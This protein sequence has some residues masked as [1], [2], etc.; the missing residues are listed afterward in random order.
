[1]SAAYPKGPLNMEKVLDKI[2]EKQAAFARIFG[3]STYNVQ[4]CTD[5]QR[6]TWRSHGKREIHMPFHRLQGA[7]AEAESLLVT[8]LFDRRA[9]RWERHHVWVVEGQLRRGESNILQR[10]DFY[11]E[12]ASWQILY[13]EGYNL[14]NDLIRYYLLNAEE[15]SVMSRRGRWYDIRHSG[16][17]PA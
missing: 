13:G 10:R 5:P 14:K 15:M 17:E 8:A 11:I 16:G 1:M 3:E 12:E 4:F 9:F 6:Y 7:Y 2:F